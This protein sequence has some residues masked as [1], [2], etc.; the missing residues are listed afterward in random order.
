MG[1]KQLNWVKN[2]SQISLAKRE[3]EAWQA[4]GYTMVK[5]GK[6]V[7]KWNPELESVL[8]T[9]EP[10]KHLQ[11]KAEAKA[12]SATEKKAETAAAKKEAKKS[13]SK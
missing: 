1:D 7:K 9:M 11:T 2:S 4:A 10:D 3:F 5:D 8:A 6:L 12:E 13:E